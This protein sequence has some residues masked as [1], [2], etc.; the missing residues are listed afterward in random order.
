MKLQE[1]LKED[2]VK[3]ATKINLRFLKTDIVKS[4]WEKKWNL[5][6]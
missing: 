5:Q 2:F 1:N 4:A 3:D 6:D